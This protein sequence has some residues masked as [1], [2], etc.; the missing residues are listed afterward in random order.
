M[1][2][3]DSSNQGSIVCVY[4]GSLPYIY[5]SQADS[6]NLQVMNVSSLLQMNLI[7]APHMPRRAPDSP[8]IV[9]AMLIYLKRSVCMQR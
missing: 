9:G 4:I 8:S 7:S 1:A 2:C 6:A 3:V 5:S